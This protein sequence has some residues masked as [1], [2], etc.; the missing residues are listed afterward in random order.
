MSRVYRLLRN[1]KELGPFSIGELLGQQLRPSDM[2]W[3]EGE[4]T[5]WCYL[6]EI[7]LTLSHQENKSTSKSPASFSERAQLE[8]RSDEL[9]RNIMHYKHQQI[10]VK[11][12]KG[13]DGE[14]HYYIATADQSTIDFVD[15]RQ[16]KS[17][18]VNDVLMTGLIV[19]LFTGGL[20]GGRKLFSKNEERVASS[21]AISV[22]QHAGKAPADTNSN[23]SP[24]TFSGLAI[25]P[26]SLQTM[27]VSKTKLPVNR[28]SKPD[29]ALVKPPIVISQDA[30]N[31]IVQ[32]NINEPPL[33]NVST[34]PAIKKEPVVKEEKPITS[35]KKEITKEEDL[36][37]KKGFLR[38]L[39]GKKKK[40][41][42]GEESN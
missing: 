35:P 20:Y 34:E 14:L 17:T 4:S 22:D 26:D 41:L 1:N 36:E 9:R 10:P 12:E 37:K 31:S 27:T 6:R 13:P 30:D 40:E 19:G 8:N 3:I 42:P 38:K 28:K 5:A 25:T 39:F 32:P 23:R 2:L 33:Q 7:E 24:L 16:Q 18:I 15:H 11:E 21:Q 29:T